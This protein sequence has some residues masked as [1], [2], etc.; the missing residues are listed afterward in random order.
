M[1]KEKSCGVIV[2]KYLNNNLYILLIKHNVG[3]WS[4]PKGHVEDGESE[5]ETALRETKEETNIDVKLDSNFRVVTTY[6][7]TYNTVKDVVYFAGMPI[8]DEINPQEKEVDEV[9]WFKYE[10][11]KNIITYEN[12]YNLLLKLKKY[13]DGDK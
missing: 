3:H 10:D 8:N 6:N 4:Y 13:L 12:D 9:K 7:T 2:Y 11:C 5:Q 1:K